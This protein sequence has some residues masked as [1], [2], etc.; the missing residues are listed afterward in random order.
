[1][2]G[3]YTITSDATSLARHFA[4]PA[5]AG[6]LRVRFNVAPS[7][8]V[9]II[10]LDG[11]ARPELAEVVWGLLP[12]W[13]SDPLRGSRPINA[14]AETVEAKPFFRQ[15]WRRRRCLFPA[16][17]FYEWQ[18]GPAGKQPYWVRR[19]DGDPLAFAGLWERWT[20]ETGGEAIE[21]CAIITTAANT[22]VRPI[23]P[24]MPVILSPADYAR[25]LAPTSGPALAALATLLAPAPDDLLQAVAVGRHVNDPHHDE[26]A[27]VEPLL[28]AEPQAP[29]RAQRPT[30][31]P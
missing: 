5:L 28:P 1:M 6:A 15:A 25:W 10:R 12:A 18:R 11:E 13:V 17:G 21:S 20:A 27:C 4:L 2:C 29:L 14:R 16:D 30:G 8:R 22:L 23:H 7:Q 26:P 31:A 9:P 19:R 3:R 24:R